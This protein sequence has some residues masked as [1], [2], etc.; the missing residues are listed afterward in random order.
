[1]QARRMILYILALSLAAAAG[2]AKSEA[3]NQTSGAKPEATRLTNVEVTTVRPA[4][5]EEYINLSGST[6]A[7]LDILISSEQGGTVQ[8]LLADRGER[9][10]PGQLLALIN[11]DMYE[12]QLAEAEANLRY[13]DAALKKADAL[14]ERQSITSMQRLQAQVDY[15]M[16]ASSVKTARIR[17]E[18]AVVVAPFGGVI[19]DRFVDSGEM[20]APGGQLFRLVDCSRLKIKSEFAE[21][22]V[23]SFKPGLYAEVHFDA[24]P[25]SVFRAQLTFIAASAHE[26]SKTFPCEFM[27]NNSDGLV[28]GGMFADI[29]VLKTV[30]HDVLVLPQTALLESE[31]GR[32]VFVLQGDTARR[33]TVLAGASNNGRIIIDQGLKPEE[34]V[35][36]TGNRELVDGQQV[37]VTGRKD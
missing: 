2:C 34:T 31:N 13:K 1:M 30:H 4:V 22:D 20:V 35:V 32:S 37:K 25:D 3:D 12:A 21:K 33:R 10:K 15:D 5:M 27:L 24:F 17:L 14:F 11:S 16:A 29:R 8:K 9:V 18:R 26:A 36:V 19:D 7:R 23:S 28:R 6:E